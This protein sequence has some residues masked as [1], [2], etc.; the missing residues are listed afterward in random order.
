MLDKDRLK[1]EMNDSEAPLVIA[2][3]RGVLLAL[4]DGRLKIRD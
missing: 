4:S 2:F 3:S 1:K